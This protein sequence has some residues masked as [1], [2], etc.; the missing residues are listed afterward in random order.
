MFTV[1]AGNGVAVKLGS[2]AVAELAFGI[3]VAV[4][5]ACELGIIIDVGSG[6]VASVVELEVVDVVG[7]TSTT[8]SESPPPQAATA[9]TNTNTQETGMKRYR[10]NK[11]LHLDH[12]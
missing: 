6:R 11:Y 10:F 2:T 1:G 8:P 5:F 7:A 9:T 12:D 3:A 4:D